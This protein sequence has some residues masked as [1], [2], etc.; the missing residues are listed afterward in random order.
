M[1]PGMDILPFKVR[2]LEDGAL[3]AVSSSGE[4]EVLTSEELHQLVHSPAE[5][6][7]ERLA[8]F[9]S[10]HFLVRTSGV[11]SRRL[12]EARRASRQLTLHQGPTLH[13]IVPTLQCAHTCRYCQVSR[14]LDE[15]GFSMSE[16]DVDAAC[17][18]ALQSPSR[19]IT[20]EFQGGDPLLR[21]DLIK[22]AVLR[23][24]A[25][26]RNIR[27]VVASTLH[28]LT[29]AVC[30]F[31][32]MHRVLLST[33]I[34]GPA[35]LHN[36]NR[37]IPGRNSFERTVAGIELARSR[38]GYPGVSAL[39]T[40][41]RDSLSR[42]EEIVDEYVRL[43]LGEIVIRPTS[44][45]GFARRGPANHRISVDEFL[46]FYARA[47]DRVLHWNREGIDI[48]EGTAAI[49]FNK[50]MSPVDAGYVD[51]QGMTAAGRAVLVYNYDGFVYPSDESRMLVETGDLSLRMGE[52][53]TPLAALMD[54]P[55]LKKLAEAGTSWTNPTCSACAYSGMCSHDPVSAKAEHGRADV[56]PSETEHCRR[57]QRLFDLF[58]NRLRNA[59]RHQLALF[60]R[61]ARPG[62]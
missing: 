15:A 44:P 7:L 36:R 13:I 26:D 10:K 45:Y 1:I 2:R 23:L 38:I 49:H 9:Q 58:V 18:T 8:D 57:S 19:S 41:T 50:L 25:R 3:L 14:S 32:E 46:A 55:V 37:P 61:W 35:D 11:G 12:I 29:P 62:N 21:F 4:V 16:A 5:L 17:D 34:D 43:G 54:S 33:S 52:I 47:L 6:P 27:L 56:P 42:P 53:G 24:R 30:D 40:T 59:D 51:L 22:R 28:Q 48:R 39:M 60:R 31:L 20:V